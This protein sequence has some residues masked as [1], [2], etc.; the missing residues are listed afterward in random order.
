MSFDIRKFF[1]IA[2]DNKQNKQNKKS[3]K[4]PLVKI[5]KEWKVFTDGSTINNGKKNARGGIGVFFND[6]SDDNLGE[7]FNINGKTSNNI[8]ELEAVRR[9]ILIIIANKDF[10]KSDKIQ[11]C[12][13]SSYVISCITIWSNN[14]EK[15]GWK[16]KNRSGKSVPVKNVDLI[17]SIKSLYKRHNIQF[18]HIKAH[19]TLGNNIDKNSLEY[20]EWYG[21]K[22]ADELANLGSK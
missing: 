7:E 8:C 14:W 3:K 15:N 21:N 11:I 16:R 17:K 5:N 19:R 10:N 9:A 1:Q 12:S 13:D 2:G 20:Q 22:R 4:K 18:K 6:Y